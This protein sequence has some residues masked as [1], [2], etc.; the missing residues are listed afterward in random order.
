[1]LSVGT[2]VVLCFQDKEN[3]PWLWTWILWCGP[4]R[5]CCPVRHFLLFTISL[6]PY[7]N[8]CK[9]QTHRVEDVMAHIVQGLRSWHTQPAHLTVVD[10]GCSRGKG[11]KTRGVPVE[12]P[13]QTWDHRGAAAVWQSCLDYSDLEFP[14]RNSRLWLNMWNNSYFLFYHCGFYCLPILQMSAVYSLIGCSLGF[15]I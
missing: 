6:T 11:E 4:Q 14:A 2:V 3:Q 15:C 12:R 13:F 5:V 1:M 9:Y 10:S 7:L 8:E